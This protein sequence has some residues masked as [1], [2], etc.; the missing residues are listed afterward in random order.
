MKMQRNANGSTFLLKLII[1]FEE[2]YKNALDDVLNEME[3][4]K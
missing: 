4:M 1:S 3:L 2:G